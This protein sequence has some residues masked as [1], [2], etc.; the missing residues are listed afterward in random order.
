L[1]FFLPYFFCDFTSSQ[2]HV[3][4]SPWKF[5][6]KLYP[7]Y[8]EKKSIT[9]KEVK[10]SWKFPSKL[11]FLH[12][13]CINKG[14]NIIWVVGYRNLLIQFFLCNFLPFCFFFVSCFRYFPCTLMFFFSFIYFAFFFGCWKLI[15]RVNVVDR[16]T[17][18]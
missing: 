17:W 6:C 3:S 7:N 5:L 4:V 9:S 1:S 18:S 15:K 12:L 13:F 8:N 16:V 2:L 14:W 10:P 11:F